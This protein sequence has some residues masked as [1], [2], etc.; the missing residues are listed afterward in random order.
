MARIT[1]ATSA[2]CGSLAAAQHHQRHAPRHAT[3]FVPLVVG[4]VQRITRVGQGEPG[5]VGGPPAD[6]AH[7]MRACVRACESVKAIG[8]VSE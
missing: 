3:H 4:V 6:D 2:A 8:I 7:D 5:A 1:A